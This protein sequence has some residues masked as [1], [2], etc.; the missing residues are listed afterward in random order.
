MVRDKGAEPGGVQNGSGPDNPVRI[1]P[2]NIRHQMG[3]DINR[4][5][6]HDQNRLL[7]VFYHPGNDL[8]E[9]L[10]VAAHKIKAGFAFFLAD[11]AG[12]DD[13]SRSLQVRVVAGGNSYRMGPWGGMQ[14]ILGLGRGKLPVDIDEN[15][16][17]CRAFEDHGIGR[18]A[19]HESGADDADFHNYLR[20]DNVS[21]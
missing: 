19:A 4:I 1:E 13:D 12:K 9:H 14:D 2:G 7:G 20:G 16:F 8:P 18:G 10:S 6:S 15:Y 21:L 11:T 5:G 3:Y 17:T